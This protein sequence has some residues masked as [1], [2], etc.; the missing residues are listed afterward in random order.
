MGWTQHVEYVD[1][2][3]I[4]IPRVIK[5]QVWNGKEFIPVIMYRRDGVLNDAKKLWLV[6][7]FGARGPRWDYSLTGNF[8]VMD[9]Q[10]YAWF[11][12]KWG[13]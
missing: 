9:E 4:D 5:K 8:Y 7:Q 2:E 11:Q 10:V 6:E 12:L 3:D 1:A 13:K